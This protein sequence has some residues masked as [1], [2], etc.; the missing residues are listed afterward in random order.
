MFDLIEPNWPAPLGVRAVST[1]RSGGVSLEPFAT[2]NL[3]EHVGDDA[4]KVAENRR[5][6]ARE[7]GLSKE[8][9]WLNQTHS[10]AVL[11]VKTN[12]V[13]APLNADGA[14]TAQHGLACVVMTA[15]CLPV[16]LTNQAG[17]QVA[18]VHAG[19]R[20]LAEGIIEIA[21]AEFACPASD[22]LAWLGPC[23]GLDAFE[24][25]LEVSQQLG[26][27][28]TAYKPHLDPNKIYADVRVLARHRLTQL[29]VDQVYQSNHCTYSE[30]QRFFSYRRD[31]QT[32]RMAS[33][34][35]IE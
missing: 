28:V 16:L 8:P 33:L 25:G 4:N 3:G 24:V 30:P 26:G 35:W 12:R 1:T 14:I 13:C 29:G 21:I 11:K 6:L 10:T 23:I 15:D 22:I 18:A 2:L 17:T 5:L 7:L 27:P 20:G 31:G 32:G 19:W 9:I 34:I